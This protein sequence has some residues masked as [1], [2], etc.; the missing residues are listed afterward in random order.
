MLG[1]YRRVLKVMQN[2]VAL[3]N[4]AEAWEENLQSTWPPFGHPAVVPQ[5][6]PLARGYLVDI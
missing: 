3:R 1:K 5:I 4:L 2:I 6:I